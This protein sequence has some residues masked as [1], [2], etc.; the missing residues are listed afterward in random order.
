MWSRDARLE[1]SSVV[2]EGDSS[3]GRLIEGGGVPL[4]AGKRAG[5]V[6]LEGEGMRDGVS[7]KAG[8]RGGSWYLKMWSIYCIFIQ[9]EIQVEN[10][11]STQY[12]LSIM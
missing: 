8:D 9:N 3:D 11:A 1:E 7:L 10:E 5:D 6:S 2:V 12:F 4:E